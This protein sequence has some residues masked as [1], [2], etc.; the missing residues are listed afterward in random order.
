MRR[1]DNGVCVRN[2][3]AMPAAALGLCMFAI[4]VAGCGGGGGGEDD[5]Q[6]VTCPPP[7]SPNGSWITHLK[8]T[9][10]EF[11]VINSVGVDAAGSPMLASSLMPTIQGRDLRYVARLSGS[12]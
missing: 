12:T 1:L 8:A 5:A 10:R 3:I 9:E 2:V 7:P 11:G 6:C 4:S